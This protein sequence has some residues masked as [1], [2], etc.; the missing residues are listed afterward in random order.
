MA[1]R[2]ESTNPDHQRLV[3]QLNRI[4]ASLDS[5]VTILESPPTTTSTA[6]G[7]IKKAG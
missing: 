3:D 1:Y 7:T 2:I 6:T 4:L 5:R